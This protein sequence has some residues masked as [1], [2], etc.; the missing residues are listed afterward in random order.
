MLKIAKLD[1]TAKIPKSRLTANKMVAGASMLQPERYYFQDNGLSTV[2][3]EDLS[4]AAGYRLCRGV[5]I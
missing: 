3:S 1:L 5:Y 2:V 4:T